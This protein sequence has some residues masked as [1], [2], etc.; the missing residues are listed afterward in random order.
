MNRLFSHFIKFIVSI[1]LLVVSL[2]GHAESSPKITILLSGESQL[3]YDAVEGIKERL[4]KVVELKYTI[5]S[6]SEFV[7]HPVSNFTD[8]QDYII[9]VGTKALKYL[10][11]SD[12]SIPSLNILVSRRSY[13]SVPKTD[14][15]QNKTSVIYLDQPAYRILML[16]KLINSEKKNKLG[17]LF[18]PTSVSEKSDYVNAASA[19]SLQLNSQFE[20]SNESSLDVIESLIKGSDAYIA[21][22]DRKVLNRK[23]A[24]WLLYMANVYRKPVIAYSKSYVEAGAIAAVYTSPLDAG[25]NAASWL[26][27]NINNNNTVVWDKYPQRFTV[28]INRKI[29]TK[30]NLSIDDTDVI[31]AKIQAAE[32]GP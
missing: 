1:V 2:Y 12:V 26:L 23:I 21:L 15:I 18:G 14:S 3:Y 31:S 4:N 5:T 24:K 10:S 19:L 17:M 29:A 8:D 6:V 30:L 27:E 22:Y 28:E 13:Q 11:I 32:V 16:A 7:N 25:R 20:D 9:A